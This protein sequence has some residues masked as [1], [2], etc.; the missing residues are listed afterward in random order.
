MWLIFVT[1]NLLVLGFLLKIGSCFI[2]FYIFTQ[3]YLQDKQTSA[4]LLLESLQQSLLAQ[5][6][7]LTCVKIQKWDQESFI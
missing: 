1:K 6:K 2:L 3:I 7:I 5:L 4:N